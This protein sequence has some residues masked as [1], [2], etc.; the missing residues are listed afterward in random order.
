MG[1]PLPLAVLRQQPTQVVPVDRSN[2]ITAGLI[3]A[4]LG[5]QAPSFGSGL[6]GRYMK[7]VGSGGN[8][9]PYVIA[10]TNS[11]NGSFTPLTA[12]TFVALVRRDSTGSGNNQYAMRY[13]V[14]G[15]VNGVVM[16]LYL[17]PFLSNATIRFAGPSGNTLS[18]NP[19]R[20]ASSTPD[21]IFVAGVWDKTNNVQYLYVDGQLVQS[22]A[23]GTSSMA[24][25]GNGLYLA[26]ADGGGTN[27]GFLPYATAA[28]GR[29]LTPTEIYELYQNIWQ[30]WTP[31]PSPFGRMALMA[32]SA[33]A[34]QI[35]LSGSSVTQS[36][37][38]ASL[39]TSIA[40]AAAGATSSTSA[41]ALTTGVNLAATGV[42]S[43]A[44]SSALGTSINLAA[45]GTTSSS[46]AA[47][48][49]TSINLTAG[50]T[51]Q[52]TGA[53][54]LTTGANWTASSTS[55]STAAASLGTSINLAA[56][57]TTPST[58]AASLQTGGAPWTASSSSASA[59]AASLNTA[60]Q[61]AAAAISQAQA[62]AALT[63]SINLA[64]GGATQSTG[65]ASLTAN[66]APWSASSSTASTSAAALIT[67]IRLAAA[68]S[69]ASG[70]RGALMTSVFIPVHP[71]RVLELAADNRILELA[72]EART[73]EL[74]G[75]NRTLEF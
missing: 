2:P 51:T 3:T 63:T 54:D 65:A 20:A 41:A 59:A 70:A 66:A 72:P 40:M 5:H 31:P 71:A 46:A 10:N 26:D 45:G 68:A 12:I 47:A 19:P 55:A 8:L 42:T 69:S 34:P 15:N 4:V 56:G 23:A 43:S 18:Y 1:A 16:G 39:S 50:G 37:A 61:I 35:L 44:A 25:G 36:S 14:T 49:G 60:V 27:T 38:G 24:T 53:A 52:S 57:A 29:A 11:T 21:T 62:S 17:P 22:G 6:D 64:A 75:E 67:S 48:L 7:R 13:R 32:G 58:A 30:L 73:L 74:A 28:W 33:S 9:D